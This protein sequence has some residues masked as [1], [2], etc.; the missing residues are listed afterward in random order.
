MNSVSWKETDEYVIITPQHHLF[1]LHTKN[2][3]NI[4]LFAQAKTKNQLRPFLAITLE[5]SIN[6][7]HFILL[8]RV[9]RTQQDH[10][11]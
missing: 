3:K 10:P 7:C 8:V 4:T 9:A 11:Y 6:T 2:L 1:D 5:L